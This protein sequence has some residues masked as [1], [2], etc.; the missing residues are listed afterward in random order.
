M[1]LFAVH[2]A[3]FIAIVIIRMVISKLYS[4]ITSHGKGGIT[5]T[6]ILVRVSIG[7][8]FQDEEFLEGVLGSLRFA[9]E[10]PK[11]NSEIG[12]IGAVEQERRG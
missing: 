2:F 1:T 12:S 8:S 4:L 7:L 10:P 3:R 6:T 11:P 9:R 5:P